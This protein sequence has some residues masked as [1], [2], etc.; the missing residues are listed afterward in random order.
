MTDKTKNPESGSQGTM[1]RRALLAR[2][3]LAAAAAYATPVA[4][5]IGQARASS[6]SGRR[7]GGRR[8]RRSYS[9]G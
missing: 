1:S 9:R 2:L 5:N 6:Y 4:L 8:R 7:W 3:G